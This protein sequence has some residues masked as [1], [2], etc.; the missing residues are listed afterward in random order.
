MLGAIIGPQ[1]TKI[2]CRRLSSIHEWISCENAVQVRA[3]MGVITYMRAYVPMISKVAAPLDALRND[4]DVKNHWTELHTK[5]LEAV[6]QILLSNAVLHMPDMSKPFTLETDASL[7]G[8]AY[9]LTQRDDHGRTVHIALLSQSL[10]VSQ[11][12]W[13]VLR[14]KLYACVWGLDRLRPL[15]FNHP[16]IEIHTDHEAITFLYTCKHLNRAIQGYL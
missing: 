11:Q 12:N 4:P 6:K 1:I 8:I 7:Y 3:L 2:D 13:H 16:R 9:A 5:S 14:R 10:S 15:L